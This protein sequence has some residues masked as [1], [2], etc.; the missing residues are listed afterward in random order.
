M[1]IIA[2]DSHHVEHPFQQDMLLKLWEPVAIGKMK[3]KN[4]IAMAPIQTLPA[5]NVWPDMHKTHI[6]FHEAVAR[7]GAGM[8]VFGEADVTP[9]STGAV[10]AAAGGETRPTK[11]I[12]HDDAI[13]GWEKLI[14]ACHKWGAKAIPQLSSYAPWRPRTQAIRRDGR[15]LLMVTPWDK[16]G[17]TQE[18]LDEEKA[19]FVAAAIRAQMA[20][21]DGVEIAGTR[22]SMVAILVSAMRNP[23]MP[24]YSEGLKERV[25][26]PVEVIREIKAACGQ[27]FPVL[28]RMS[29]VEYIPNGYDTEYSKLVAKEFVDAGVDAIDVVQA[30]FSTQLPQL[31]MVAPPGLYGHNAREVKSYLAS[32]GPPYSETAIMNACRIQNPWQAASLIRNGNCDIVSICRQL[33]IDP[34]WP[35]KVRDG[36]VDDIVPCIGC[37]WCMR[38]HTCAVNPR[39]PFYKAP[40][41]VESL[42]IT[43]AEKKKKV[44][45]A[46]GGM[47]GMEAAMTLALRGHRVTLF[48][49]END[50]GRMLYVQSL[51]PFRTDMDLVR[52]YLSGQVKK[53]G[54]DVRCGTEATPELVEKEKP[55][56]VI[57][58]TGCRPVPPAIPGI[59]KHPNVVFAEDVLLE[60]ADIGSRVVV[61]D[62]DAGR[63]LGSLGSF[64]ANFVA[65]MACVRDD[66]AMH[67][68]RWSPQHTPEQVKELSDTPV[69]RKVTVVSSQERIAL[70]E[71]HHYTTVE[72]LR[73]LGVKTYLKCQYKEITEKGLVIIVDGE[74]QLIEADTIITSNYRSE[75]SLYKAL[76]GRVPELHLVGDARAIQVQFIGN[77]HGPYRL[78]LKI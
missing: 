46:G 27:D 37:G 69:G 75:D 28:I 77:I 18:K 22:E 68:M 17:M 56:A 48:E 21:A 6:Q 10:Q 34:E 30:G 41:L 42:K 40:E 26:F 73:R 29:A 62:A 47:A 36:R 61:I 57:V 54:V 19:N 60:K 65:R 53:L 72:D 32:L 16:L 13:P 3:L 5:E 15:L 35:D 51:A 38:S 44:L 63:D 64:T 7:G 43:E 1:K 39:S 14:S 11:G 12:W 45:I 23:G 67:I 76:E 2:R 55:D 4:R 52:T 78:S 20:G 9:G 50:L 71:Y 70:V 24:G 25:R 66:I 59:E 74:E 8:I 31:Q 49:K 33:M 58:A